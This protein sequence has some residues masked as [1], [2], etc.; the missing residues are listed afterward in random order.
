MSATT[1]SYLTAAIEYGMRAKTEP[2]LAPIYRGLSKHFAQLATMAIAP[3][4]E[5]VFFPRRIAPVPPFGK[6]GL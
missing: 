6:K 4:P 1:L 2:A 5:R 3:L